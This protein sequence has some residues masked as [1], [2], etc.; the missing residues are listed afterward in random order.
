MLRKKNYRVIDTAHAF[1]QMEFNQVVA[2]GRVAAY[3][4]K[5]SGVQVK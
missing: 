1:G 3:T 2:F 5:V 4:G